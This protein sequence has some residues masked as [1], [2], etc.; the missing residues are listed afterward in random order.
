M[1]DTGF[2]RPTLLELITVA[3][4][5]INASIPGAD[6]RLRRSVLG[7]L[8]RV[9][10]GQTHGLYEY[11]K[12]V[13]RQVIVDTASAE[14]LQRHATIWGISRKAATAASGNVTFTGANGSVIPAG[15]EVRRA[16]GAAYTT[17]AEATVAAGAATVGVTAAVAGVAGNAVPAIQVGLSSPV[18]GVNAAAVV[19]GAGL[20]GGTDEE[21]DDALR[22]RVLDRIQEPPHGG[23]SFD[24]LKWARA[25]P[26][27]TR[28]WVYPLELG[29]GTVTVRF[30][31]DSTYA[32]GIPQAADV[33]ALQAAIDDD[34]PVTADVVVVAPVAVPL[35]FTISGID[36]LTAAVKAAVEAELADLIRREAEPAGTILI[37]HIRE[38][39][40]LASGET[41]HVLELPAANVTHGT[42]EIAI[43]GTVTWA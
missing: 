20:T 9:L 30:M 42:G 41:D 33:A 14:S 1:P 3:E 21:T 31:M 5:E 19:A 2:T 24:Y 34:R 27:V 4:A 28:A 8:A 13:S 11:I 15:T 23:A 10:A 22:E 40:S 32:D 29:V 25:F 38:A 12:W 26:G 17:T 43:M 6:A 7:V 39:I 35:N 37:S 16:D 18:A 36:P